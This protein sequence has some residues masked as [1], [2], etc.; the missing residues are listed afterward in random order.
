M[1]CLLFH[2]EF[3]RRPTIF[4]ATFFLWTTI[5]SFFFFFDNRYRRWSFFLIIVRQDVNDGIF[6][7]SLITIIDDRLSLFIVFDHPPFEKMGKLFNVTV[8]LP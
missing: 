7:R 5:F 1:N 4:L 3:K 6:F 2:R 8:I